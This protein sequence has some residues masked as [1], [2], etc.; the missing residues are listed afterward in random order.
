LPSSVVLE[1]NVLPPLELKELDQA[2]GDVPPSPVLAAIRPR[3]V[4]TF[5]ILGRYEVA[6]YGEPTPGLGSLVFFTITALA[7]YGAWRLVRG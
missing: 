6:P 2:E 7:L 5:P 3:V 4:A 1:S